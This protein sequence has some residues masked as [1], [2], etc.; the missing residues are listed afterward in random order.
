MLLFYHII[1]FY[2]G[3]GAE[4]NGSMQRSHDSGIE[5][6]LDYLAWERRLS[7]NTVNSYRRDLAILNDFADE[8]YGTGL[9][10]ISRPQLIAFLNHQRN[11]GVS[12]RTIARRM[13]AFRGFF[14]YLLSQRLIEVSPLSDIDTPRINPGLY[15]ILTINEVNLLISA[16][17]TTSDEGIR[18]RMILE[19]MYGTGLRASE[20]VNL[21]LTDLDSKDGIIRITG[22]GSKTRIVPLHKEGWSWIKKYLSKPRTHLISSG[23]NPYLVVKKGKRSFTRQ[24]LWKVL[25]KYSD[26]AGLK[27]N[28]YPHVLRHSF[29]THLLE[30]GADLRVLQELLGHEDL[31]TTE[32]YTNIVEERKRQVFSK[33]H[34]RA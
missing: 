21:K 10:C 2:K 1:H 13:S 34:P 32:I 15:E 24:D 6:F 26:W 25:K 8:L 7:M 12:P 17:D 22:K 29:A 16:P 27:K 11:S 30:G 33:S 23:V 31:S 9:T 4:Y 20:M 5:S 19:V 14:D 28:V 18:D 3:L